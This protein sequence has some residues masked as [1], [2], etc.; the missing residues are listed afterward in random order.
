VVVLERD[1]ARLALATQLGAD[2][3]LD[4][5]SDSDALASLA[6]DHN[7]AYADYVFDALP[8]IAPSGP[9]SNVRS[10]AMR[11]LQAGGQ[12]ILFGATMIPQSV[13]TWLVLAKGLRIVA[14]PFD[15]RAF[16]MARTAHITRVALNLVT[17]RILDTEPLVTNI[18][19]FTDEA[20]VRAAFSGYGQAGMLRT[21]ICFAPANLIDSTVDTAEVR[22]LNSRTSQPCSLPVS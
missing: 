12:Y 7:G 10:I 11:L 18:V 6:Y 21:S 5:V 1:S 19:P 14:T 3:A 9:G 17:G 15:V 22:W 20:G 8:H 13:D 4:P 16:P 2:L